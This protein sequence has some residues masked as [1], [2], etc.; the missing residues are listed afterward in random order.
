MRPKQVQHYAEYLAVRR[1]FAGQDEALSQ[2]IRDTRSTLERLERQVHVLEAR[3]RGTATQAPPPAGARLG[4]RRR[5]AR[6]L[7]SGT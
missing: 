6:I 5:L 7:G 1:L 2:R 4:M 3:H